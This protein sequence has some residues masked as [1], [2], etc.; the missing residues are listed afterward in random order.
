MP[1]NIRYL[2]ATPEGDTALTASHLAAPYLLGPDAK[3]PFLTLGDFFNGLKE[4]LLQQQGQRL[5]TLLSRCG[6]QQLELTDLHELLIRSEKHG[7]LYHIASIEIVVASGPR[8]FAVVTAL[9]QAGKSCL[10]SEFSALKRLSRP[11][12]A[13]F[14]PEP[15]FHDLALLSGQQGSELLALML[16]EWLEGFHEWHLTGNENEAEK[17]ITVWDYTRGHRFGTAAESR[18][19]FRQAA[20]ILTLYYEPQTGEQ[21]YPWHHAAGDFIIRTENEKIEV[22]LTTVRRYGFLQSF[23]AGSEVAPTAALISFFLHLLL[24]IRLDKWEGTGE[25]I[26]A[27]DFVLRATISGFF[28]GIRRLA[29]AGRNLPLAPTELLLLLRSFNPEEICSLYQPLLEI[30]SQED[31]NDFQTICRHLHEHAGQMHLALRDY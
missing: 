21:I 14:L 11:G 9:T 8:K 6:Q 27:G 30:Y 16:T 3:H 12:Q 26:W 1:M 17:Q 5:L 22:R 2:I 7:A 10:A 18:E 24:R 13:A 29:A 19:I 15:Y 31:E 28:E 23:G 20:M 4:Y 25:T